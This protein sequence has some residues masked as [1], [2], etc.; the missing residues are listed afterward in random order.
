MKK[1]VIATANNG[2]YK[3]FEYLIAAY[4]KN[5]ADEIIFAPEISNLIVEETGKTYSENAM[6]KARAWAEKSGLPCLADDSGLEVEA[7]DG[8]PGLFSARIAEG[9]N[10]ISWLLNEL[11]GIENRR[12]RFAA[13]LALCVPGEYILICEGFCYGKIGQAPKGSNGFGYDPL[14]IPDGF[15]K[16][17]AELSQEIKNS[18]SHRTNAFK[19]II[20]LFAQKE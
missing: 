3:E 9:G 7:L 5:F 10:K 14:F 8:A 1:L 19:K 13:S 15:E 16:T 4:G 17:F 12:A 2:K 20:K 6:L 11:K 18:I